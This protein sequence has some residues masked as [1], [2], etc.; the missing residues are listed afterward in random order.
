MLAKGTISVNGK[1]V[2]LCTLDE[3]LGSN[4]AHSVKLYKPVFPGTRGK[5]LKRRALNK[6]DLRTK[7]CPE[8]AVQVSTITGVLTG[9]RENAVHQ[10]LGMTP[11]YDERR[12]FQRIHLQVPLFIRGK[13]TYG[14]QFLELA[15]TLDISAIGAFLTSPRP[16]AVN[17]VV[18]LT[19]PA[20]SITSSALVPAGMPPI[21]AR[22]KRQQEAGDVHLVGVEF[23]KPIG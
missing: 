16:L 22:V 1:C 19:I 4:F 21:Q 2:L 13:D 12:R 18:T 17:E 20:P 5:Y 7:T 8:I 11:L 3:K 6:C 9:V 23:L 10:R 14:E 15:K